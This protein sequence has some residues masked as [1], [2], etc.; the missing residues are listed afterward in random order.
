MKRKLLSLSFLMVL[1]FSVQSIFGQ[2]STTS[3]I[4]GRVTGTDGE[5]LPGATVIAVDVPT[6]SQYGT[7]TNL[8][9]YYHLPNMNVGGPYKITVSYVGYEPFLKDGLYLQLGQTQKLDV[10]LSEQ[11]QALEGVEIVAQQNE[12]F[13]GNRTGAETF[14]S[15]DQ[16]QQMPT[17][18]RSIADFAR[19]TPQAKV[20]SNG[21]VSIAGMNNRYN[22]ISIDG[23]VNNDVFGL[24]AQGTNGGQTGATAISLDAIDQFQITLAP[25]DVRQGGFAG[26][27]INAVTRRGSNE[28]S[29][30]AYYYLRNQDFAGKTPGMI[31]LGEGEEREKLADFT[32]KT[33]G[34]RI[35]GPIIKNKLFFF[36]NAEFQ[37]DETPKPFIFENY[38]GASTLDEIQAFA[39]K[40]RND[41]GYE[42]G[43]FLNNT[44]K[45]ESDK[46]LARIDWNISQNHKLMLRHSYVKSEATIPSS[47]TRTAINFFNNGQYFPSTTNST[48]L[49]LKSN[50]NNSNNSLIIGYTSVRDDRDP[51]GQRFPSLMIFDDQGTIYAGSEPYS[52][53]NQLDQDIFTINDNYSIYSGA[54]TIT[55]GANFELSKTYNLFMRKAFGEYRYSSLSDFMNNETVPA[56]QYE[57][58]YSLVDDIVGDGSKAAADF[59]TAQ[60]GFYVQDEWQINDNFSLTA[61]VR[62]DIPYYLDEPNAGEYGHVW[63]GFNDTTVAKITAYGYDLQGARAGQMPKPQLMVNPRLGFNWD[64]NGDETTQLRGGIGMFTSRLPLV[65]PGGAY[66]NNGVTIGGVFHRSSWGDPIWFR[67]DWNSQYVAEDFGAS[68]AIPSGQMDLFTEDF[69]YPQ[70]LRTSIGLDKKLPWGMVGTVEALYTKT[71]N[72]VSYYNVNQ[73]P[74]N[75]VY[76]TGTPDHRPL[77]PGE[78]IE[79]A[80][81]R[82]ILGTNTS[83]GYTY[84]ITAQ[85]SKQFSKGFAASLA[86]TFGRAMALND[87]TSSQNSSQWRYMETVNGLNHLDLSYSDFDLG[88][89][90]MAFLS[91]KAEYAG[92]FA[93]TVSLYY[94]GVSGNRYS[95]VYNDRGNLNGEGENSGNLIWIPN[96]ASEI[97]LVDIVD[98]DGVV[99]KT[100]AEQWSDLN[101]FINSSDYLSENRG[102]YAERNGARLPFESIVDLKVAQDFYMN[103]AG[104]KHT[105]QLT[106]DIFNFTNL[107]NKDW[108]V[109]RFVTYDAYTLIDFEGYEENGT[110]PRLTYNGPTDVEDI[111]NVSDSGIYSSRWMAQFGIR[112]IFN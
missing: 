50:W 82:I 49:E 104:K 51:I 56:Y 44:E 40:L 53:G 39:D 46:I 72:N 98:D 26:A 38:T 17:I 27:S 89:R 68:V 43:G 61:G 14:I 93:T 22:A 81:T 91:Y 23:A 67:P 41:Y 94:S 107:L 105:L 25:Y 6:G 32:A 101:T 80:Y 3:A 108:G 47:S 102:S 64:V 54:H 65:W 57:R 30:S 2:G 42:P 55:F 28:F 95:F 59:R 92:N 35:G 16:I 66:T 76:L 18:E 20:S 13:D 75:G 96:D 85:L 58:G 88:S 29:G 1:L 100:A 111:Y 52:T 109:R 78:K 77:Y 79:D 112:Y 10:N 62:F 15:N 83:E 48:A 99:T 45:L 33:Y 5:S 74:S 34:M 60:M 84:N 36:L 103:F 106:L 86:Y 63:E 73:K 4:N 87:G 90:V 37:R 97:N 11:A 31:Q 70:V 71:I 24:S 8:D 69:K 12:M 19:L 7:V 21:A 9:G 110:T